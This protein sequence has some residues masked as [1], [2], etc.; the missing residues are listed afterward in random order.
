MERPAHGYLIAKV[1]NGIVGP[2]AKVN[3]GRLYPLLAKMEK[4]GQIK[5]CQTEDLVTGGGRQ[6]NCYEITQSGRALFF[7]LML[8]T[9]SNLSDYQKIFWLKAS[10]LEYLSISDRLFVIE[11]YINYCYSHVSYLNIKTR[12][13]EENQAGPVHR[14]ATLDMLRHRAQHWK[15]EM[16]WAVELREKELANSVSTR[17]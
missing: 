12:Q 17:I 7:Q 9:T 5:P 6:V 2:V 15:N 3:N 13:L 14:R 16:E 11:H 4:E 1:V 8:D 10:L